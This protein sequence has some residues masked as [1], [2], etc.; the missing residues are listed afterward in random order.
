LGEALRLDGLEDA[1]RG[2]AEDFQ[3]FAAT[4]L[5]PIAG[6]DDKVN[7]AAFPRWVSDL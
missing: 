2:D 1:R 3:P 6:Y 5:R 4:V 7:I